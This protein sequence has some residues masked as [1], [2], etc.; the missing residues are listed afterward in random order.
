MLSRMAPTSDYG[1]EGTFE[2]STFIRGRSVEDQ[3]ADF[4]GIR[5]IL[6]RIQRRS[7]SDL[8]LSRIRRILVRGTAVAFLVLKRE[9]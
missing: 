2:S 8:I 1:I 7:V 9:G 6:S 3:T 5:L 4:G